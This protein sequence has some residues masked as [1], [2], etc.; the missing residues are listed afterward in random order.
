MLECFFSK[1]EKTPWTRAK[2]WWCILTMIL[3]LGTF[4][5]T[6]YIS[7][8]QVSWPLKFWTRLRSSQSY[9]NDSTS[10]P[11]GPSAYFVPYPHRY[12][13]ILDEPHRCL[14]ESPFLVLVIPVAPHNREARD[15]IRNTWGRET[16]VLG[17][18]VSHYFLLGLSKEEY[19]T[20]TPKEQVS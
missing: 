1:S 6:F 12:R 14:Q 19:G 17:Q 11:E 2:R 5:S 8:P 18:V 7:N 16:T 13:F 3:M 20:A 9:D 4:M 10:P 15:T